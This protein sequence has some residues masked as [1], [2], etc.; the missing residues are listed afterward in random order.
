MS[1]HIDVRIRIQFNN[2]RKAW[3]FTI[4][5][6]RGDELAWFFMFHPYLFWPTN[7]HTRFWKWWRFHTY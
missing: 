3:L 4:E 6:I 5:W 2:P 7:P 1:T